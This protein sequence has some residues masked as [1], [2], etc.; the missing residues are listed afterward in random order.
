MQSAITGHK[1]LK[2]RLNKKLVNF[3]K[4][5]EDHKKLLKQDEDSGNEFYYI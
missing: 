1:K 5:N 4:G 3:K 2:K